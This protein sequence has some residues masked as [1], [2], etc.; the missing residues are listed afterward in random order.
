M[1]NPD[2]EEIITSAAQAVVAEVNSELRANLTRMVDTLIQMAATRSPEL[3]AGRKVVL[4]TIF[5][6]AGLE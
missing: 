3:A 2:H 5:N 6:V 4:D 1:P